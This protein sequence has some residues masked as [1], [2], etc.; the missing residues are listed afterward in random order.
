MHL[1]A[2]NVAGLVVGCASV[3]QVCSFALVAPLK[4]ATSGASASAVAH[5]HEVRRL[6]FLAVLQHV[7]DV[8]DL[9]TARVWAAVPGVYSYTHSKSRADGVGVAAFQTRTLGCRVMPCTCVHCR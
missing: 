7:Y 4:A 1:S 3:A 8:I 2:A 5:A 6:S 9:L